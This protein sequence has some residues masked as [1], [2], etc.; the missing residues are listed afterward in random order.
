MFASLRVPI[1]LD[2]L[3]VIPLA[4]VI[5]GVASYITD[6]HHNSQPVSHNLSPLA[7]ENPQAITVEA[8]T[9]S[10]SPAP[11]NAHNLAPLSSAA[12]C[13]NLA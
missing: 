7:K 2:D 13:G 4:R 11:Q 3:A 9:L 8:F 12:L 5:S 10:S 6:K 1:L